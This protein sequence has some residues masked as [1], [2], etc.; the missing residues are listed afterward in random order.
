MDE[1]SADDFVI[2]VFELAFEIC[3]RG[4]FHESADFFVGSF[5]DG[6]DGEVDA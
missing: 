6:F 5:L 2:G 1:V 4:F 3:F